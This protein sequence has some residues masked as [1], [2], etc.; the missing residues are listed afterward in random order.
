MISESENYFE[1]LDGLL[2]SLAV[3]VPAITGIYLFSIGIIRTYSELEQLKVQNQIL[4]T[5]IKKRELEKKLS[6]WEI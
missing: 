4:E 5:K 2:I 1:E 3:L 6:N